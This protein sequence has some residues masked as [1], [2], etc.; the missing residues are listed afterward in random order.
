MTESKERF[1][2]EKDCG[3]LASYTANTGGIILEFDLHLHTQASDG[4]LTPGEL[5]NRVKETGL[6]GFS[7]TDHDV[8]TS[9]KEAEKAA[10]GLGLFFIPGVEISTCYSPYTVL[11]ILGYGID[12]ENRKLK[13]VLRHNQAAWDKSEEDSINALEKLGIVINRE[14]HDF[15]KTC[16][17]NGGWPLLNVLVEMG[18]VTGAGEYFAK[19]F[20]RG[21]PAYIDI[22]FVSTQQAISAIK[23]AGGLAVLAHPGLYCDNN[24]EKLALK[25]DFIEDLISLGIQGLEAFAGIHSPEE[26]HFFLECCRRYNLLVTG[27]SDYHGDFVPAR[28]LGKPR[29]GEAYLA[30]L[31]SALEKAKK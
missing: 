6:A 5:A 28:V 12:P 27:G 10:A 25:T 8:T 24:N 17:V 2:V 1:I 18:L 9:L 26:T 23:A 19:Y 11:H 4:T 16:R 13:E 31:L 30:P 20:G 29:L 14:R 15:W 22:A 21:K 3:R 7:V